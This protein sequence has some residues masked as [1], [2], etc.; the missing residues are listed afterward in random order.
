M[1]EPDWKEKYRILAE[2]QSEDEA[3]RENIEKLLCRT[4]IR[5][6]LAASGL[7]P[8]LDPNLRKIRNALRNGVSPSLKDNLNA[9]SNALM[10]AEENKA[11]AQVAEL[12]SDLFQRLLKRT[13]LSGKPAKQL[14]TL[15][16]QLEEDPSKATDTKLDELLALIVPVEATSAR[17]KTGFLGRLLG[18]GSNPL[19]VEPDDTKPDPNRV[20]LRL[21]EKLN[22][23]GHM[24]GDMAALMVRLGKGSILGAWV[25]VL[26]DLGKLITSQLGQVQT[27]MRATE[28]FL[29]ELTVRL[30]E[31]DQHMINAQSDRNA[32]SMSGREL[33]A[34][35]KGEMGEIQRSISIAT[36][37]STLKQ[38]IGKRLDTIQGHVSQHLAEEIERRKN[39]V[40]KEELLQKRL[41]KLE[42]ET[43]SLHTKMVKAKSK[44]L[45][46]PVTGLP[47]RMAYEER[48][49]AEVARWK[50]TNTP[51]ALLVW[52]ID[53]FK[54]IN[55]RFGHQAGDKALNVIGRILSS[56]PREMDFVGRYGGE[57][58]VMLL[59]DSE[60]ENTK[61]LANEI[62]ESVSKSGF[63]SSGQ[64]KISITIS[65]GVSEFREGDTP[66]MV[67]ERADE[68]M[69]T[70]KREGKNRVVVA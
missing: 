10:H 7:D 62:R 49:A 32:S 23:P 61:K 13:N 38:N 30:Q 9:L 14:E 56:R 52:D 27:E 69:Y 16:L 17:G 28:N 3:E 42:H 22:W 37:L 34:V 51:L 15:A 8:N 55:D 12:E 53:D 43:T 36:D 54:Q 48:L 59:V 57:E 31:L 44:A 29:G 50:R 33:N 2:Q 63:H 35:V 46:D 21:L 64:E 6:T 1:N 40:V 45:E 25:L 24:A 26:E 65:C 20:L 11:D 66:E 5:L 70:A 47:N 18:H 39:A 41:H 19:V 58:F 4:I 67:F 68:A 60:T